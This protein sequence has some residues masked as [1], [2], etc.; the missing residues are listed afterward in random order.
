M[1]VY[2]M[3]IYKYVWTCLAFLHFSLASCDIHQVACIVANIGPAVC[4]FGQGRRRCTAELR[5]CFR[6]SPPF[7][8]SYTEST[9]KTYKTTFIK[10][11]KLRVPLE[12]I[13]VNSEK[14]TLDP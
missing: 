14:E 13:I 5:F 8:L 1:K 10:T 4:L 3:Y 11:G 7:F 2:K 9:Q 6:S 12:F